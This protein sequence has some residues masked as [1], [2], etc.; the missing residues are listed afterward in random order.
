MVE[1][2]IGSSLAAIISE[3]CDPG[4]TLVIHKSP[5]YNRSTYPHVPAPTL[6]NQSR[7]P[8]GTALRGF[9]I[10]EILLALAIMVIASA[11]AVPYYDVYAERAE[12]TAAATDSCG[13]T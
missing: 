10:I 9:T 7:T 11:I 6:A 12:Q 4:H 3:A 1:N 8:V 13:S 5:C 2:I